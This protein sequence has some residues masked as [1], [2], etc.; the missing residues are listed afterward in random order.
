MSSQIGLRE[1]KKA[2]TR[3]ALSQVAM[4]LALERGVEQVTA[5]AIAAAAD[6]APRTFHNYFASKE[7]AIV[8]VMVDRAQGFA[9]SLRARPAG[10]PVWDALHHAMVLELSGPPKAMAE[11]LE[12]MRMLKSSKSLQAHT[13]TVF[14]EV[15]HLLVSAIA[16]RTGFDANRDMYPRLLAAVAAAAL[17]TAV[18]TWAEDDDR[19]S[20]PVALATE[21]LRQ[22]RAGL[23]EPVTHH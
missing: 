9:D 22:L 4:R 17:K 11:F 14:E 20:T 6:V 3:A 15:D 12:Q 19:D 21:A 10:E 7:E 16:E 1:R 13:L 18:E 5:E 23:P 8:A 2:A